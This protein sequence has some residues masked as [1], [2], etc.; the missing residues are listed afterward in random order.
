MPPLPECAPI[1][2]F[3]T[4]RSIPYLRGVCRFETDVVNIALSAGG[5]A[6]QRICKRADEFCVCLAL[7]HHVQLARKSRVNSALPPSTRV[8]TALA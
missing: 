4:A 2:S 3:V 8:G 7:H 5:H 1:F 6:Q